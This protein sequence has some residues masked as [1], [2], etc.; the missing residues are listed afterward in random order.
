M[1]TWW[2]AGRRLGIEPDAIIV[3]VGGVNERESAA[4]VVERVQKL[5]DKGVALI[6]GTRTPSTTR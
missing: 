4:E 5:Q 6:V 2:P 1:S 3:A